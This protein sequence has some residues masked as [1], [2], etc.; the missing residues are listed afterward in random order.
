M[1]LGRKEQGSIISN[2]QKA[3]CLPHMNSRALYMQPQN[4]DII[5]HCVFKRYNVHTNRSSKLSYSKYDCMLCTCRL[6]KKG[7]SG[8]ET[9]CITWL[10]VI[11]DI[12]TQTQLPLH[13]VRTPFLAPL[14][15]QPWTMNHFQQPWMKNKLLKK[16]ETKLSSAMSKQ[17][18]CS[19]S[20]C[21]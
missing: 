15:A 17:S 2:I 6:A 21:A 9:N 14:Q 5:T 18:I 11:S 12:L 13:C 19:Q 4:S 20:D 3:I 7:L 16:T 1:I 10:N 8:K